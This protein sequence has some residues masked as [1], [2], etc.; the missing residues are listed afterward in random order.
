VHQHGPQ[1]GLTS[2]HTRIVLAGVVVA[3]A[4]IALVGAIV[5]WPRSGRPVLAKQLGFTGQLVHATA[6]KVAN[7]PCYDTMPDD[8]V[9]CDQVYIHV[10]SG[11]T[12]GQDSALQIALSD[13]APTVHAGDRIVVQYEPANPEQIRYFFQDF[14]RGRP[15]VL[16]LVL[17]AI[18]VLALGRWQGL[19]ALLA[20]ALTGVVLV[21]FAFPAILDGHDPTSVALVAAVVI[22]LVALYLTHGVTEM[23][24]VALLGTFAALAMTAV[25]ALVFA[26]LAH[27]TGF[28]PEDAAYLRFASAKIDVQGLIL[29]GVIVGSL[30][31]VDDVT[32]TQVSAVWQ[33]H[34]A[35]PTY[36]PRRLYSAA[37]TIGRDHIASTVNTL[38][39][40]YAGASLPLLLVFTAA[41][42]SLSQV[43]VG[44]VVAVEVV[45]T[46]VGSIGLIAAVPLTTA[47]AVLVVTR[48]KAPDEPPEARAVEPPDEPIRRASWDQ[49]RPEQATE[50]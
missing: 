2:R 23:I 4:A 13:A 41:G 33:L 16:L 40:A 11:P 36:G 22:A 48:D 1:P 28:G 20:L 44:E 26:R 29:A 14:Q 31:V 35:N 6:T 7:V 37:I 30:G 45:R 34:R 24:T 42:R 46:L 43:V 21:G 25:L 8:G 12:R 5:L 39:L 18:A 50:F 38:V 10:T 32:V 19:R 15:L 9:R 3:I 17:F 27:F 49:F 47:L